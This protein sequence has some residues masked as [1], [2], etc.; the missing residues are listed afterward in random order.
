MGRLYQQTVSGDMTIAY[1]EGGKVRSKKNAADTLICY[2]G[3][4]QIY[5]H[6]AKNG[7]NAVANCDIGGNIRKGSA[8]SGSVIVKCSDGVICEGSQP[9]GRVLAHFDGDM[10]GA[11]AAYVATVLKL[12]G[13]RKQQ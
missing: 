2:N 6:C 10:Y 7:D 11:A 8:T 3:I 1:F 13:K 5:Q 4:G 9:G 12:G